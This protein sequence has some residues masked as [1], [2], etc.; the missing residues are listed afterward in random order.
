MDKNFPLRDVLENYL[1]DFFNQSYGENTEKVV[2]FLRKYEDKIAT[3]LYV[4]ECARKG[5]K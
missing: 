5:G 1:G 4:W 2:E 3:A